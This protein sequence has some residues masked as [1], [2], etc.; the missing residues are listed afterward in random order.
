M[1]IEVP[2]LGALSGSE[3][4]AGMGEVLGQNLEKTTENLRKFM[5]V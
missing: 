1:C 4:C 5:K 2:Y 3:P